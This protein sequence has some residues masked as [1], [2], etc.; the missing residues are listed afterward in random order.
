MGIFNELLNVCI[1]GREARQI[2]CDPRWSLAQRDQYLHEPPKETE[3][4][5]L[6]KI[7]YAARAKSEM[8][9]RASLGD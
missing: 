4:I 6:A 7:G 9:Q 3:K 8:E 1:R 5:R 2:E